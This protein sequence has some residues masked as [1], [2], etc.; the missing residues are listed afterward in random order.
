[1][2][3]RTAI[4]DLLGNQI[5]VRLLRILTRF[6]DRGFTGRELAQ[7]CHSSPSQ[8]NQ[9]LEWLRDSGLLFSELV[10]RAHVWR[11][12]TDHV[13][14][15]PFATLFRTERELLNGLTDELKALVDGLPVRRATIFGSV[16]R[17]D[18]RM[19]SD[20]DLLVEVDSDRAKEKVAVALSAASERFAKRFGNSLSAMVVARGP[21]RKPP[22]PALQA[23]IERDGIVIRA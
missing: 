17:G 8:T 11:L 13:L 12:E 19:T 1:M 16:A 2:R 20:I 14:A 18:E 23:N 4:E 22:N 7:A 15:A 6:P 21:K 3:F 10:G 5:R 9:V